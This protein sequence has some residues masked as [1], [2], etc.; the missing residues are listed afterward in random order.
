MTDSTLLE[1]AEREQAERP[2]DGYLRSRI[3]TARSYIERSK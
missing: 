2:R 3:E 1:V